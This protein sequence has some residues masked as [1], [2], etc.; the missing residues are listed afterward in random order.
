[1]LRAEAQTFDC[2]S[3]T[4]FGRDVVP[5]VWSTR[6]ISSGWAGPELAAGVTVPAG[7]ARVKLPA[8]C[9]GVGV[10]RTTGTPSFSATATAG[11]CEP[12]AATSS[13]ALRSVR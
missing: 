4:I 11:L 3:G 1:M 7:K 2:F 12:S 6:P 8:P 10:R 9:S 5:D 13:L